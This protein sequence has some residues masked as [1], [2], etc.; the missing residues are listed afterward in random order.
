MASARASRR[1][2]RRFWHAGK[3]VAGLSVT[4][5][6]VLVALLAPWLAP[7]DPLEQHLAARRGPPSPLHLLGMDELGRDNLSRV[8]HGARTSLLVG[9]ASVAVAVAVGGTLGVVAGYQGG[10]VD[11][12]VMSLG[13]MILSVPATL[14]AIAIISVIGRGLHSLVIALALVFTPVY[15]RL[16]RIG[17]VMAK[18]RE[19]VTAA[20]ALGA[21]WWHVLWRH[22]LPSCWRPIQV[23]AALGIG[24]AILEGAGLSFL[25]LGVQPPVPEWGAMLGQGRGAVFAAPHIVLYPGLAIMATVLGFNLLGD[26]LGEVSDPRLRI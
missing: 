14:S 10:W 3:V 8:I 24:S 20:W 23:Q 7:Y 26:G 1:F 13:E 19:Y 17:V 25:G 15:V 5:C 18:D 22:I 6:V 12:L 4:V 16:M 2:R 21:P 9:V 11:S